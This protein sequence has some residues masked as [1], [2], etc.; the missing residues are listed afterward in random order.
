MTFIKFLFILAL[1]ANNIIGFLLRYSVSKPFIK[2]IMN[3][4]NFHGEY[5]LDLPDLTHRKGG[6][7]A[8]ILADYSLNSTDFSTIPPA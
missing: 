5:I 7:I 8:S 1:S 3:N 6:S 2:I 4:G